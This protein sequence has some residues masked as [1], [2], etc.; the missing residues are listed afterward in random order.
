MYFLVDG[1]A[2]IKMET[3]KDILIGRGDFFGE[4]AL[5]INTKRLADI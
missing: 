4:L 2:K 3:G 5:I 1:V